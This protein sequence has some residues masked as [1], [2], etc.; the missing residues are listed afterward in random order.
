MSTRA[1]LIGMDL[2]DVS[3]VVFFD[4]DLRPDISDHVDAL[5]RRLALTRDIR[6]VRCVLLLVKGKISAAD[7][8]D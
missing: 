8:N 7:F 6:I 1:P 3:V 5:C 2:P 4:V